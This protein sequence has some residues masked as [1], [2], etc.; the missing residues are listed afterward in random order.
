MKLT[1]A[2]FAATLQFANAITCAELHLDDLGDL[3][4]C[5]DGNGIALDCTVTIVDEYFVPHF[6]ASL[7]PC[8]AKPSMTSYLEGPCVADNC[9]DDAKAITEQV[10]RFDLASV[11]MGDEPA[12]VSI[13]G[14]K[15]GTPIA[16]ITPVMEFSIEGNKTHVT[17]AIAV[18]ACFKVGVSVA[19]VEY[20]GGDI[21]DDLL[22]DNPLPFTLITKSFDVTEACREL[23][24]ADREAL[25]FFCGLTTAA[26][27]MML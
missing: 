15:I 2:F 6:H 20:C 22:D 25:P 27:T 9:H 18:D 23:S 8:D 11:K 13:P 19:S 26:A 1:I 16:G 14:M 4:T 17:L 3:C 7:K 10:G 24:G 5:T 12:Q 21:P